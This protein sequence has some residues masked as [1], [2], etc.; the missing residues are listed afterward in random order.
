MSDFIATAALIVSLVALVMQTWRSHKF[1]ATVIHVQPDG[2]VLSAEV[3]LRNYG[4]F[5]ET[6]RRAKFIFD[7][8]LRGCGG[9]LPDTSIG[10]AVLKAGEV[11]VGVLT[12]DVANLVK[13]KALPNT[14]TVHVG[15]SFQAIATDGQIKETIYRFTNLEFHDGQVAST[16]PDT[17]DR[18]TFVNLLTGRCNDRSGF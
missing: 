8:E 11:W 18:V 12:V 4:D 2:T 3:M 10:P 6:F 17:A 16:A 13:L 5:P 7:K 15:V 1:E 14:G 9:T